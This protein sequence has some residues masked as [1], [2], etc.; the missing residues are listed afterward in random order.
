[1]MVAVGTETVT[2]PGASGNTF[3]TTIEKT[4]AESLVATSTRNRT[5]RILMGGCHIVGAVA[6]NVYLAKA[7]KLNDDDSEHFWYH[8]LY[9][10]GMT[11]LMLAIGGMWAF[12]GYRGQ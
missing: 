4:A 10:Y 1:L 8:T 9:E 2:K 12:S 11:F 6:Y 5:I 3:D 7:R